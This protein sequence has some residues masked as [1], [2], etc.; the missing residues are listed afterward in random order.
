MKKL[1]ILYLNGITDSFSEDQLDCSVRTIAGHAAEAIR[2]FKTLEDKKNNLD[3]KYLILD[4]YHLIRM[5]QIVS[6]RLS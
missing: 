1:D 6:I 5:D 2:D 3:A 4:N